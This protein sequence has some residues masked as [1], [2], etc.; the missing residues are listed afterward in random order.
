F[1]RRFRDAKR[2]APASLT[3]YLGDIFLA[4]PWRDPQIPSRVHV[5]P[6]GAVDGFIGVFPSRMR[7]GT[8][9][10]RAGIAGSLMVDQPE[11]NPFAGARL[12]HAFCTGPQDISISETCNALTQ[13]MWSKLGGQL[14]LLTS[15]EWYRVLRPAGTGLRMVTTRLPLALLLRPFAALADAAVGRV[16][17]NPFR[18]D[19]RSS[20]LAR[21]E[22]A[23]EA[24]FI[25]CAVRLSSE[26][27]FGP[28]WNTEVL[29]WLLRHAEQKGTYGR[30]V[31]RLVYSSGPEPIGGYIYYIR[32]AS[33]AWVLQVFSELG[34]AGPILDS[35]L[36]HALENGAVAV[37]GQTHPLLMGDLLSRGCVLLHRNSTM[38]HSRDAELVNAAQSSRTL[39]TGLAGETWSRLIGGVFK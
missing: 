9:T 3:S 38:V 16:K 17:K 22:D 20:R 14:V 25:S 34:R 26:F 18:L 33:T 5:S 12:L 29:R 35:L 27:E 30:M 39:M 23:D 2:A 10:V 4:H 8:K 37:R 24:S 31:R 13:A 15:M 7:L 21:S 6:E 28:N 19:T 32:P 36:A 1:Q 11:K